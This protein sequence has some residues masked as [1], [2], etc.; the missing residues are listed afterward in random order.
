METNYNYKLCHY[1]RAYEY[2]NTRNILY[3]VCYY[4]FIL[5]L[6]LNECHM[7]HQVFLFYVKEE[8]YLIFDMVLFISKF[9]LEL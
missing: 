4:N 6:M 3:N 8:I 1:F 7:N 5:S 9:L 2:F